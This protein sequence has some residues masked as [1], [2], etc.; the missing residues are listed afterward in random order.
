MQEV[1]PARADDAW[2]ATRAV[3]SRNEPEFPEPPAQNPH[4]ASASPRAVRSA[5]ST[6]SAAAPPASGAACSASLQAGPKTIWRGSFCSCPAPFFLQSFPEF[7]A[8]LAQRVFC[9]TPH[10]FPETLS[11][12]R[13][14]PVKAYVWEDFLFLAL[15]GGH[16]WALAIPSR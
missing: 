3:G 2:R 9:H 6:A 13:L 5:A 10:V 8:S 12:E 1:K 4:S 15:H 16:S 11:R 14:W 7:R